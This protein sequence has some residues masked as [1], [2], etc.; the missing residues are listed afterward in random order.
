MLLGEANREAPAQAELRPTCAGLAMSKRQRVEWAPC[1]NLHLIIAFGVRRS[2]FG[3][4]SQDRLILSPNRA[5]LCLRELRGLRASL[6]SSGLFRAHISRR[7]TL[8]EELEDVQTAVALRAYGRPHKRSVVGFTFA[9]MLAWAAN[10][11]N[12]GRVRVRR[13]R[14]KKDCEQRETGVISSMLPWLLLCRVGAPKWGK[15]SRRTAEPVSSRD[16]RLEMTFGQSPATAA[17][18]FEGSRSM[19]WVMESLTA[20]PLVPVPSSIK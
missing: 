17:M 12:R 20:V 1:V 9:Q 10:G 15:G 16:L 19:V 3:R 18:H 5:G 13:L 14:L 7:V 8:L 6:S 4:H 11:R 2:P